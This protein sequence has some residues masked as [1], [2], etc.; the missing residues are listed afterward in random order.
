MIDLYYSGTP[1]GQKIAIMLEETELPYR[2][3][4]MDIFN[5]D[6][7]TPEFGLI[8]PNHKIPAIVDHSPTGGEEPMAIFESGAILQYLAE[9]TG[10]FLA[11]TGVARWTTLQWLTW[12]VSSVGPMSGQASHF[13]RYAPSGQ[14]YAIGRYTKELE[15][16]LA[17]LDRRLSTNDFVGGREYTIADIALWPLRHWF[18]ALGMDADQYPSTTRWYSKIL[19]RPAVRRAIT[20]PE[21]LPP[22]KYA[23]RKQSLNEQ[24][25]S[26]LFGDRMHGAV[27]I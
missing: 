3:I 2:V 8:N 10:R 5:G 1:N 27:K 4:V 20:K 12:Q 18:S 9:R 6:Q 7:L 19:E 25:W 16:L 23:L 22:S 26:N 11:A 15:R 13:L 24:E 14:D 17:V 21:L